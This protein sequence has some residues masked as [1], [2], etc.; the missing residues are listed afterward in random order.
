MDGDIKEIIE[1]LKIA[2]QEEQLASFANNWLSPLQVLIIYWIGSLFALL[3]S[4]SL[5]KFTFV[6]EM[7]FSGRLYSSNFEQESKWQRNI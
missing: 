5:S 1:K 4:H 6:N 7:L 3:P 2:N